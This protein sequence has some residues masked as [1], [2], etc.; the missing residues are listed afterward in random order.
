MDLSES[1]FRELRCRK[2]NSELSECLATLSTYLVMEDELFLSTFRVKEGV[3]CIL[4]ILERVIADRTYADTVVM[5]F[6]ALSMI[7]GH[8]PRSYENS[9]KFRSSIV[10]N[11]CRALHSSL[12]M[13]WKHS[14]TDTS[15]LVDE[16]LGL[17]RSLAVIDTSG[18]ILEDIVIGDFLTFC[19]VGNSLSIRSG[20]EA[21][22]SICCKVVF[23]AEIESSV[24]SNIM[25]L[26][27][28]T[29]DSSS[30][31]NREN[32]IV[33]TVENFVSPFLL[34][35]FE[36]LMQVVDATPD[37]WS[38]LELVLLSIGQIM[39]RSYVCHRNS[40]SKFVVSENLI[41][42]LFVIMMKCEPNGKLAVA[43]HSSKILLC[44][45]VLWSIAHCSREQLTELMVCTEAQQFFTALFSPTTAEVFAILDDPF[46]SSVA[47]SNQRKK[48]AKDNL[49]LL[50][51]MHLFVLACSSIPALEFSPLSETICPIHRWIWED[52]RHEKHLFSE[53]QCVTLEYAYAH[54]VAK[55]SVTIFHES[56]EVNMLAMTI[57]KLS[58]KT[59]YRIERSFVPFAFQL[60]GKDDFRPVDNVDETRLFYKNS[61]PSS[62]KFTSLQSSSI[63]SDFVPPPSTLHL[64]EVY[65]E[66]IAQLSSR[67]FGVLERTMLISVCASLLHLLLLSKKVECAQALLK[68][69]MLSICSL[70]NESLLCSGNSAT[71]TLL[72][73]IKWLFIK[74]DEL[75][76]FFCLT[77][78]RCGLLQRLEML[79]INLSSS[80]EA[81]ETGS[82][83]VPL[84]LCSNLYLAMSK[85]LSTLQRKVLISFS[86]VELLF[87]VVGSI[88][89][90]ASFP[91]LHTEKIEQLLQYLCGTISLT[92]F[93]VYQMEVGKT[94]LTYLMDG[95]MIEDVLGDS[96]VYCSEGFSSSRNSITCRV[97]NSIITTDENESFSTLNTAMRATPKVFTFINT[98][99]LENFISVALTFPVGFCKM[100]QLLTSTLSLG[101]QL[102]PVESLILTSRNVRCKTPSKFLD[103]ISKFNLRVQM[104][105]LSPSQQSKA[106]HIEPSRSPSLV[107]NGEC[108]LE[109]KKKN[110]H[111]AAKSSK[112]LK[113][114]KNPLREKKYS[115]SKRAHRKSGSPESNDVELQCHL[116]A[117]V[118]DMERLLRTGIVSSEL[119]VLGVG[120]EAFNR[121]MPF[122][123][124]AVKL[125][126]NDVVKER[127]NSNEGK[128]AR[129]L[130]DSLNPNNA[131]LLRLL[132]HLAISLLSSTNSFTDEREASLSS[133]LS[134]PADFPLSEAERS[135]AVTLVKE[136]IERRFSLFRPYCGYCNFHETFFGLLFQEAYRTQ[137]KAVLLKLEEMM[138]VTQD[139]KNDPSEPLTKSLYSC[140][141]EICRG[142]STKVS[143]HVYPVDSSDSLSSLLSSSNSLYTFHCFEGTKNAGRCS[144]GDFKREEFFASFKDGFSLR[145]PSIAYREDVVLLSL[146]QQYRHHLE[147]SLTQL[148]GVSENL[149]VSSY[150]TAHVVQSVVKSAL[151]VALLPVQLALPPWVTYVLDNAKFLIPLSTREKLCRFFAC[152]AR[153]ALLVRLK[154][155]AIQKK[156]VDSSVSELSE[157]SV[158]KFSVNRQRLLSDATSVLRKSADSRFPISLEFEGDVGVGQGP[159]AQ[160]YTLLSQQMSQKTLKLW[161]D[162]STEN[163][164]GQ[165][166]L[167]VGYVSIEKKEGSAELLEEALINPPPEGL[168]P[169][170]E[171]S[172]KIV[173]YSDR[174]HRDSQTIIFDRMANCLDGMKLETNA[175][176][177]LYYTLGMALGRAFLD[178]Y[179]LP[180]FLSSAI[181]FFIRYGSPPFRAS[182]SETD[183]ANGIEF[184]IDLYNLTEVDIKMVDND[185]MH[186]IAKL[187][188]ES[189]ETLESLKI[190]FSF[191]GNDDFELVQHGA[192]EVVT[193]ENLKKYTKRVAAAALYESVASAI[194]LITAGFSDV[195]PHGALRAIEVDEM[196]AL[197]C[198][199]TLS[200]TEPLWSYDE[201]RSV[202]VGDHGYQNDSPQIAMLAEVLSVKLSPAEQQAFLLFITGCPRLPLGGIRALG[203]VTVVK[204]NDVVSPMGMDVEIAFKREKSDSDEVLDPSLTDWEIDEKVAQPFAACNDLETLTHTLLDGDW[205]LPSVNTC[206]RYLKLPPY[207][208]VDMMHKKLLLSITQ[209]GDT[210]ELS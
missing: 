146:F 34:T 181:F 22:H 173:Q 60:E 114:S 89:E 184:P 62:S 155:K 110:V 17:I 120:T 112:M 131:A 121:S 31:K 2:T 162:V 86:K 77:A 187:F 8:V 139:E 138:C 45:A 205:P 20:L 55:F 43:T 92:V 15:M 147:K 3:Q 132:L 100:I 90:S 13:E 159:T 94:L 137:N 51:G 206:F 48:R 124:H 95:K 65:F 135:I 19:V 41:K 40:T 168:F 38:Q 203:A 82:R 26:F 68:N 123:L 69:N 174:E 153:R 18:G 53:E 143:S 186:S 81:K 47:L 71:C 196:S 122:L 9:L 74:D 165:T 99:R 52:G 158:H 102:P 190:P 154:R 125:Y 172:S 80:E 149:F 73:V 4:S 169:A 58:R 5:S 118:G 78:D 108:H 98:E 83:K 202:L 107:Q 128:I 133:S 195:V 96:V 179:V 14:H 91:G 11:T 97:H 57:T 105:S 144:C 103:A 85:K 63:D 157:H 87:A 207:P 167:P 72:A 46:G 185:L 151:R 152:G 192:Q 178:G 64:A 27:R 24:F 140:T 54:R 70:I 106:P 88:K 93:E 189:K 23:P 101:L 56:A 59:A 28:S 25:S 79:Y 166:P 142:Q 116:M 193:L 6:R 109:R 67:N 7:F 183:I 16:G 176:S 33:E 111:S 177:T 188:Q 199:K 32:T 117:T 21:L 61:Q 145:L 148:L 182:V 170:Q 164:S 66:L 198:G 84:K 113:V 201:I 76:L 44:E 141:T 50:S 200:L 171:S 156:W 115:S 129:M 130:L 75:R 126:F 163:I 204:R 42:Q 35:L 12:S 210:F 191:P 37:S 136:G 39:I 194:H 197:F 161:K 134:F 119:S 49:T 150:I 127:P 175:K 30:L 1:L 29:S 36:Q 104:C 209:C 160:F 208:S 180:L 10:K